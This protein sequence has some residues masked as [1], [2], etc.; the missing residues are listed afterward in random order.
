[1]QPQAHSSLKTLRKTLLLFP[2]RYSWSKLRFVYFSLKLIFEFIKIRSD[3]AGIVTFLLIFALTLIALIDLIALVP[4]Y[5]F[6]VAYLL[7][8]ELQKHATSNSLL[9]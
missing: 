1:M 7:C 3:I 2:H 6:Y 9:V 4:Q 5:M 8:L